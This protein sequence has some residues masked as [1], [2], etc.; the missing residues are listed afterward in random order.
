MGINCRCWPQAIP[1]C[2]CS[3]CPA[4]KCCLGKL[5]FSHLNLISILFQTGD[6]METLKK[7]EACIQADFKNG[8]PPHLQPNAKSMAYVPGSGQSRIFV[9]SHQEFSNL[10]DRDIQKILRERLILVHRISFD[11]QYGWDLK[12]FGRIYDVDKKI[13]VHGEITVPIFCNPF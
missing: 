1:T 12:S 5:I 9:A 6:D 13:T 2:A 8:L 3:D 4:R 7:V 11:Y 10:Q